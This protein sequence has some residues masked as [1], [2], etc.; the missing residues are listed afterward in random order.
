ME[1]PL[2]LLG[3]PL[4]L[5]RIR[6]I[7][8]ATDLSTTSDEATARALEFASGFGATLLAVSVIDPRTLQL[9][10]ESRLRVDQVR[11]IRENAV[12]DLIDRGRELGIKVDYLIWQGDPGEAI[13]DA[14]RAEQADLIV[15]GS[16]GRGV[17]SRFLIGS[18]SDHVVRHASVPVLVVRP[19]RIDG[20]ARA[21]EAP[22]DIGSS[23]PPN[24]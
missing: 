16:H 11:G 3:R 8:L 21:A 15:V 9:V 5:R 10:G 12:H 22:G 4:P 6:R 1:R 2:A 19:H 20:Q 14:A 7:L 17:V 18:V 23:G 13:V 24:V